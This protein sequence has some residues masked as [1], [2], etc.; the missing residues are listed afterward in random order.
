M[1]HRKSISREASLDFPGLLTFD[2]DLAGAKSRI[3]SF[4][5]ERVEK[6]QTDGVVFEMKG[7]INSA[8]VA[9]LCIEA[10]GTRR[11]AGLIMPDLRMSADQDIRDGKKVAGELCLEIHEVDIAPIHKAFMKNLVGS[12]LAEENLRARI[13]MSILYYHSN[14]L[15]RLVAGAQ[16]KSELL[17]G[18]FTKHGNGG[19]DILPIGD[20]YRSEVRKL[21]EI[22]GI[23]RKVIAKRSTQSEARGKPAS[24]AFD[25]GY[26]TAD[27]I[28]KLRMNGELDT[29]TIASKTG[30]SKEAAEAVISRYESSKHK[31]SR[32]EVCSLH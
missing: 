25:L 16:D 4:I 18:R 28:L 19:N 27:Q 20:L 2:S 9:H 29:Q 11:V 21:G 14:L 17:L 26:D 32:P 24:A 23:D 22:L 3:T 30:V 12:R 13:R 31:R 6:S 15:N 1:P 7:D 8:V 10:L 5:R